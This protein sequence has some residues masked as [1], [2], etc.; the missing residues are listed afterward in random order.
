MMS[1]SRKRPSRQE[2]VNAMQVIASTRCF[3]TNSGMNNDL[4]S[5][6]DDDDLDLNVSPMKESENEPPPMN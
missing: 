3:R 4:S 2:D 1:T 6:E 5:S